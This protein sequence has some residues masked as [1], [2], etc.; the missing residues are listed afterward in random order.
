[1]ADDHWLSWQAEQAGTNHA[2][3]IAA[4]LALL[5]VVTVLLLA[6]L[7]F[8]EPTASGGDGQAPA[9]TVPACARHFPPTCKGTR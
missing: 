7:E 1:M 5:A 8:P 4:V 6:L 3:S 9:S 2:P